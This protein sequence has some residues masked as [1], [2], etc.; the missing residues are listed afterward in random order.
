MLN[1]NSSHVDL[2]AAAREIMRLH[3]FQPDFEPAVQQQLAGL[4]AHPP[5]TTAGPSVRDLRNLLWSSIDNDTS[6]D[7]DQIEVAQQMPNGDVKIM[8]GIADVDAFVPK[9]SAIDQHASRETTSVYTGIRIFPMLPEELSTG[10]TSLLENQDRL[11]V[12]TEFVVDA[13]GHVTASDVY[14]ALV[15]NRAQLQ[16]NSLGAWLEGTAAAPAKV[17]ASADLQAQ[18]RLQDEVAQKLKNYR[19]ENGALSLQTDEI[20]PLVQND[21]VVDVVQQQKNHAT[22]LIEDFMI[23]ANGVVARM[24]EKVSSLRRI[25]KNPERWDRI[26]QLAAEHG[27]KLPATPDSKALNEFLMKRKAEDP[28]HFADVSLTVIKLMGPGEYVLERPGDPS[29]GHFGLAVH[30]YTHSTAPNRRFPDIVTQRLIKAMLAGQPNPYSDDEL[31]AIAANC[32]EKGD[33]A[34]KV[35]RE[36]SKRL[37]AIAMQHRI[38]ATFDAIVTG[39]TPKGTFVRVMQPHVEGLL[40]HGAQGA[41]VGDRLRVKLIRTDVQHGFIDFARV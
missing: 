20:L 36:M 29:A 4:R 7:L 8:V 23:A 17:A 35:E 21:Q 1:A 12:V 14:R 18:L 39:A 27:G 33:A 16:Y 30:D 5:A 34:R 11:S 38:G 10:Q 3:G 19:Q 31:S 37:A 24:L 13:G 28:D 15:R 26:V 41:D 2:Q 32:T 40:A 9:Q 22:D 25:V 6:R